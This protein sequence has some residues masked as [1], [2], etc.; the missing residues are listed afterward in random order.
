[1]QLLA[2]EHVSQ[3]ESVGKNAC[4]TST[5]CSDPRSTGRRFQ[6]NARQRANSGGSWTKSRVAGMVA[7][8]ASCFASIAYTYVYV[9][10][11]WRV[12]EASI[13]NTLHSEYSQ[14]S[15]LDALDLVQDFAVIFINFR[16]L[17]GTR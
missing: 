12:Q 2:P 9:A 4:L 14:P 11:T 13:F 5:G 3:S 10:M 1:M 8:W 6:H 7:A 17:G 16:K 15:I